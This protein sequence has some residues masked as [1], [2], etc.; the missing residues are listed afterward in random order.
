[1]EKLTRKVPNSFR[2][3]VTNGDGN[4]VELMKTAIREGNLQKLLIE[5]DTANNDIDGFQLTD[6]GNPQV[7]HNKSS[8]AAEDVNVT[9]N[10]VFIEEVAGVSAI[11]V[12]SSAVV[13]SFRQCHWLLLSLILTMS[14]VVSL[15]HF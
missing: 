12:F 10:V 7:T 11:I 2:R 8:N 4:Y 13:A 3:A 15:C 1:M 14:L 9:E 5:G 6:D